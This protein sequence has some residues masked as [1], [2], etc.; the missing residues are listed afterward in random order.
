MNVI[1]QSLKIYIPSFNRPHQLIQKTLKLLKDVPRDK[2]VV[3][4]SNMDESIKYRKIIGNTYQV[5]TAFTTNI[6]EK[7]NWIRN[8]AYKSNVKYAM[9]I[10]DDINAIV[11]HDDKELSSD[12]VYNLI[13][14][15]FY[16]CEKRNL[17]LWGICGFSNTFFLKDKTTTDL[18]FIIGN[19]HGTIIDEVRPVIL[20]PHALLEDYYFSCKHFLREGGVLRLGG[21]GTKTHFAK[22]KGGIQDRF[23]SEQRM[24][25]ESRI[26][27]KILGEMPYG[28][29]SIK[30]KNRG[31]NL[32]LNRH[33]K[34]GLETIYE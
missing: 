30:M 32:M 12:E 9:S 20:T 22:N 19:F 25:Y 3:V 23:N 13:I 4:C 29:V 31:R 26:C 11:T 6:G 28:M 21:Y 10:D 2:I 24:L 8:Y 5:E 17:S 1:Q 33:W 34:P 18:K 27:D 14:R 7:R 16:E 15:G